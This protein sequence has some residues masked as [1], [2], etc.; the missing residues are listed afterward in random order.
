MTQQTIIIGAGV[1]GAAIAWHLAKRGAAVTVLEQSS[2]A[3]GASGGSFGWINANFA[4][5]PAYFAL[6]HAA[7]AEYRTL[8]RSGEADGLEVDLQCIGSLWW[9]LTGDAFEHHHQMLSGYGY[10]VE[11]IN[12]AQIKALEPGIAAPPQCLYS[13]MESAVDA[14]A[15]TETFLHAARQ[16]GAKIK[17]H[18]RAT[19]FIME[20]GKISGVKTPH[21]EL[22]A[23]VVVV[24][25]GASTQAL[26]ATLDVALPT[27][28]RAGIILHTRPVE[29]VVQHVVFAPE[30]HFW[31]RS[32]GVIVAG[33]TF[34]DNGH[35]DNNNDNA[36]DNSI[37]LADGILGRL[38]RMLPKVRNLE[39]GQ[40]V[41]RT[42]PI[43]ADGF[44]ALGV[45]AGLSGLYVATMHSGVT[46][47]PL[48][49]KLVAQ[50][51]L[52]NKRTALLQPFHLSRFA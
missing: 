36:D 18:C 28:N 43:P 6:R 39:I 9:E 7:M 23:K 37:T 2:V 30:V 52:Q 22:L 24:A 26:L 49:G 44:P 32:D 27:A 50:E 15:C 33:E 31:Q 17:P 4:E 14:K 38:K 35:N 25:A 48:V 11:K 29:R 8:G 3:A 5:S 19:D 12:A 1:V 20:R 45:P 41:R 42:R 47:A 10:E 34:S 46:L 13:R 21:G 40:V 16:H 51:I